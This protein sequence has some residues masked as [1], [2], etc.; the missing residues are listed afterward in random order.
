MISKRIQKIPASLTL[1]IHDRAKRL[2]AAGVDVISLTV[3]EPDFDTPAHIKDAAVAALQEGFTKYT[4]AEGIPELRK[5][6]VQR[7]EEDLDLSYPW[8][9]AIVTNGAK[10]GLYNFFQVALNPGDEVIV[11]A[12][13]WLSYPAM[14]QLAGGVPKII[15][16]TLK[17]GFKL[18]P[19][20]LKKCITKKTK[21]VLINSPSNPTGAVYEAE[22]LKKLV[23]V[24]EKRNIW[25]VSDDAYY[26]IL[27]DG[28]K[29]I[30]IAALSE[31]IFPRTVLFHTCS[32]SYAMTGW[33][34]GFA[35]GPKEIIGAMAVIQSQST[36]GVN[37][38]AQKA[39]VAAVSETRSEEGIKAMVREFDQRRRLGLA[40]L[41]GIPDLDCFRPQG[42]FY[43]WV[44]VSK[45]FGRSYKGYVN[46]A[47][48]DFSEFLINEAL[49]AVIPGHSSG[50]DQYIRLSFATSSEHLTQG[51]ARIKSALQKLK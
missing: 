12:P 6:F 45:Y 16:T 17:E 15:K 28:L 25:V 36:S 26:K 11:P 43:F 39:A 18:T 19:E 5:A 51:I 10:Q 40:A 1:L 34:V 33:R 37:A 9:Q 8:E 4:P 30:S 47:S 14:I 31:K 42:A 35:A 13:Y 7:I 38:I 29:F 50:A 24:L 48:S 32:K 3:G 46:R 22:D 27:Y 49:V 41:S 44:N 2:K 21:A 20:K 23:P